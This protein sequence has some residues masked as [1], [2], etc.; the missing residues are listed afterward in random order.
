MI[1]VG[2]S[3]RLIY[4]FRAASCFVRIRMEGKGKGRCLNG[5][6]SFS[7]TAIILMASFPS[8]ENP[9]IEIQILAQVGTLYSRAGLFTW[10]LG[11]LEEIVPQS[12]QV[13]P[14]RQ[15]L[16][17]LVSS[18][19]SGRAGKIDCRKNPGLISSQG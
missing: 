5:S 3:H 19:Y 18:C 1:G 4:R 8:Q 6:L 12:G 15:L 13:W 7:P 14:P 2:C 9:G 16:V 10:S 17:L 11:Q